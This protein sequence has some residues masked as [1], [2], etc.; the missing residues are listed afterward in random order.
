MNKYILIG[1]MWLV[2][3]M[4]LRAQTD[5]ANTFHSPENVL[6][7]AD[8]LYCQKDYLRAISEY[9]SLL[10]LPN[11][12]SDTIK[13]KIAL[14]FS[15]MGDFKEAENR[16]NQLALESSFS[17][18]AR[19]ELYKSKFFTDSFTSLRQMYNEKS[20]LP[21]KYNQPVKSL[22]YT[23][24]LLDNAPLPDE[25][26]FLQAYPSY[27]KNEMEKFYLR[28]NDPPY[29]SPV[30]AALLSAIIPGLGK[31]YA[32]EWGDGL[33]SLIVTGVLSY[34]SYD[35][36]RAHHNFRGYLF[37]GLAALFYA[38]N[39][40]GSAAQAQIFNAQVDFTFTTDLKLYLNNHNY[41]LP[42]YEQFCK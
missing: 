3:S 31:A 13:F 25:G 37:G 14:G 33:T 39:V 30:K 29:K 42:E 12:S 16:F 4:P 38:G 1:F 19:L 34:V 2:T 8:Y 41:F 11:V 18:E 10:K 26:E 15:K 9:E 28:K 7:F 27:A 17:E 22:Y 24:Y 23:S 21:E 20:L 40:Y 5:S 32:G 6:K 36:L 35:N